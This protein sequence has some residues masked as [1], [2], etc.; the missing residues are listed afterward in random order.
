MT[1]SR[2]S[3]LIM[4]SITG[5]RNVSPESAVAR[6]RPSRI[7]KPFSYWATPRAERP[8]EIQ[9]ISST[10]RDVEQAQNA[11]HHEPDRGIA[12]GQSDRSA[13]H[14]RGADE[15]EIEAGEAAEG[16][17]DEDEE[18]AGQQQD[19]IPACGHFLDLLGRATVEHR[20]R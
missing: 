20:P 6:Y 16:D 18:R 12:E 7:T 17:L 15:H 1:R 13:E 14:E 9:A 2:M 8:S 19:P 5:T 4:S 11:R 10:D 3:T